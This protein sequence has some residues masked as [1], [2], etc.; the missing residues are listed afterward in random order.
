MRDLSNYGQVNKIKNRGKFAEIGV[1]K[2][3]ETNTAALYLD[4]LCGH[5]CLHVL[6]HAIFGIT[7]LSSTMLVPLKFVVNVYFK[8]VIH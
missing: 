8:V 1:H 4:F 2:K 5:S 7:F 3:I 6:A